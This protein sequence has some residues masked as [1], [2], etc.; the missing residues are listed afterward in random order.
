MKLLRFLTASLFSLSIVGCCCGRNVVMD[1]C[2]PCGSVSCQGCGMSKL[3]PFSRIHGC[4][5]SPSCGACSSCSCGCGDSTMEMG[6]ASG[7]CGGSP[8]ETYGTSPAS[9]CACGQTAAPPQYPAQY[10]GMTTPQYP[11]MTTPY[12]APSTP[13]LRS[14]P[15]TPPSSSMPPEPPIQSDINN[16][17]MTPRKSGPQTQVVSYE[18]F[19]RLPGTIISGPGAAP[20]ATTNNVSSPIQQTAATSPSFLLPPPPSPS[21]PSSAGSQTNQAVWLPAKP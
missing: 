15:E 13:S 11:S 14:L 8:V 19:Q 21:S 7:S 2:D 20:P 9:S 4:G 18:E 10:P 16:T 3:W 1:P 5:W 17:M 12:S 6:C